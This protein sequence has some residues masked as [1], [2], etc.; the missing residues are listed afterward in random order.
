[1]F[2]AL[3]GNEIAWALGSI[4][5]S[6]GVYKGGKVRYLAVATPKRIPRLPDV[7][8]V[9][10]AGGPKDFAQ[11]SFVVLAAPR[12]IPAGARSK[13]AADVAKVMQDADIKARMD[14]FAFEYVNW[15]PEEIARQAGAKGQMYKKLIERK[16][17]TLD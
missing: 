5:S 3:A 17:I 14:T 15:S 4:P 10:E 11:S 6:Q 9:A 8:T 7:P 2:T 1:M 16:N 13:I 12:G